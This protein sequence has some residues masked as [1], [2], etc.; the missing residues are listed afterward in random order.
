MNKIRADIEPEENMFEVPEPG[1]ALRFL[2]P[3]TK[4]I[5]FTTDVNEESALKLIDNLLLA[6]AIEG[7][8]RLL[9][10]TAGGDVI[11]GIM[12]MDIIQGLNN[13]VHGLVCGEAA[14]MGLYILQA[15]HARYITK[16]SILFWHNLISEVTIAS[17]ADLS[18]V[19]SSYQKFSK[20]LDG[21]LKTRSGIT[22]ETWDKTFGEKN[23]ISFSAKESL[24]LGMVDKIVT[25]LDDAMLPVKPKKPKV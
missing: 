10:N 4:F 11:S 18:R 20:Q 3:E 2:I 9:I 19:V 25:K 16:N 13:P 23:N 1:A 12:I 8:T 15:C 14:S 7:P 5:S 6:D 22:T 24:A 21:M 17:Q